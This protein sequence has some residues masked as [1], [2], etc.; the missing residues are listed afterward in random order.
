MA[1]RDFDSPGILMTDMTMRKRHFEK[2]GT[3]HLCSILSL[4]YH[5]ALYLCL[6]EIKSRF[7]GGT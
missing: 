6:P 2:H 5:A 1:Y 7:Q 3:S 4:F